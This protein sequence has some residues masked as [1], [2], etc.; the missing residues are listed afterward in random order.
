VK[1]VSKEEGAKNTW[2][3]ELFYDKA[4]GQF[5]IVW[6]TTYEGKYPDQELDDGKL[7]HRQ[8]YVTT[9]DFSNF[10]KTKLFLDPGFNCIDATL[11]FEEGKYHLVFKDE[12]LGHKCLRVCSSKSA[13][14]PWDK[15]S[16]PLGGDWVEGPSALKVGKEWLVYFDHYTKPQYI[17]AYRSTDL[18]EWEEVS[19]RISFPK[20]VRHGTAF[21]VDEDTLQSRLT[22]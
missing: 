3:P 5:L 13:E 19:E 16:G 15:P 21:P 1:V 14:G 9:K 12:R 20:G 10:S 6:A 22:E 2:A 8:Y 7:N 18:T 11:L 4:T 17:G